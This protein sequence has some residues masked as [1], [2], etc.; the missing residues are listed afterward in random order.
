MS[1][2][3]HSQVF[4]ALSSSAHARL[5]NSAE[6][7]NGLATALWRNHHDARD[8]RSPHH[9]TLTCYLAG[10]DGTF[11]R[12]QP[13]HK[14][15]PGKLCVLPAGADTSWVIND[16]IR[17]IHLYISQQQFVESAIRLLDREPRALQLHEGIFIDDPELAD[18][19]RQ[20]LQLD[21][22]E[23]AERLSSSSLAH[24]LL[25][26]LL[27]N[28]TGK[29]EGLNLKGGLAPGLRRRLI[30]YIEAHLD[31]ALTLDE[32]ARQSNLS[33]YHFAHMFR[34]S[35]AMPPHRYVLLQRL[36]RA[37]QL[38][39]QTHLPLNEIALACGFSSASHFSNRFRAN[40]G[41]TPGD[42]R[43]ALG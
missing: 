23:P 36:A 1:Q 34:V 35:F 25:S 37:R 29:R 17:L 38:L 39:T 40:T 3:A 5:E 27:L 22:Q 33:E 11:R 21:W 2:L 14:G 31:S 9:H 7:G 16:Q 28:Q 41:S 24:G 13:G 26:N 19:F 42:Y 15:A 43:A 10:G 6:L 20:L 4:Q 32:L 30:D 8:Y 12:E 18:G